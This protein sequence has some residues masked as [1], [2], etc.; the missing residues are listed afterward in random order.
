MGL[1][2]IEPLSATAVPFKVA[3]TAFVVPHVRVNDWPLV[4]EVVLALI[5]AVTVP[6]EG[7]L[8]PPEMHAPISVVPVCGRGTP[9]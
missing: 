1:T 8:V 5:P 4:I 3:V 7:V 9:T 6:A 2:V